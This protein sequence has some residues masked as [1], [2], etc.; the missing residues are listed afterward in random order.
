MKKK[1]IVVCQPDETETSKL[2]VPIHHLEVPIH[3]NCTQKIYFH[4]SFCDHSHGRVN[5]FPFGSLHGPGAF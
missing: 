1:A 5:K 2:E 3:H 4:H